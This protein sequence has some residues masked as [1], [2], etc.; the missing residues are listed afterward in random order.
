MA[1]AVDDPPITIGETFDFDAELNKVAGHLNAQHARLVDLVL[2]MLDDVGR[3]CTEG[4]HTPELF[5]GWR[6]GLSPQRARQ[7]VAIA[8]R[9]A[10]LPNCLEAFRRGEL[11]VDQMAA[12]ANRAPWWTDTE[13]CE[14]ATQLTV[15]QLRNTLAK[16]PFPDVPRPD[17]GADPDGGDGDRTNGDV[18]GTPGGD[19]P[20][21]D[22]IEN[23]AE[24]LDAEPPP[25]G[26][27]WWGIGDDDIFRLNLECDPLTGM[28]IDAALHEARDALFQ[29]SHT[30]VS[31]IDTI[32]EMAQR[33]LD[34][35]DG[36][37]RRE[38]FRINI[39]L[40]TD[41]TAC[42]AHGWHLPDAI[43]QYITCDGLLSPVFI[44]RD[45]PISVGRTQRMI[46]LRTRRIV[47]LRDQGCRVHGCN[48][49]HH[50][51][52]HHIV[53][54]ED[55][56]P[57][58]TWNL[59]ALCPRHHRMHHR[60]HLGITGNADADDGITFT[61]RHG[62]PIGSTGAKP[63]PPG[64]APPPPRSGYRHPVGER[65]DRKWLYFNPPPEYRQTAWAHHPTNPLRL[66]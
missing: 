57:T 56:G 43:R 16:Y 66:N 6:V 27:M 34:G 7:I 42:D 23:G 13:I 26:S 29:R 3:W 41:G 39:H 19:D 18:A 4:V 28:V 10:D 55:G 37:A 32:L 47:L 51:E 17:A 2:V 61:N 15:G 58:D 60:G 11:A 59:I 24:T 40:R 63:E 12:I 14:L 8:Q 21:G 25:T 62:K 38:R 5:L 35:I 65:L 9:A 36:T 64:A 20:S 22:S 54:W 44:D 50:I 45:V 46:P 49:T 33:S 1:T 30:D 48:Q 52:I 53:H 31:D